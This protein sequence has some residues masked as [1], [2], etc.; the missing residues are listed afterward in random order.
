M[1]AEAD[2]Q[3]EREAQLVAGGRLA[4]REALG[5]VVKADPD[6]DV[7]RE[8]AGRGQPR[9]VVL[10]LARRRRAR[11]Q[12]ALPPEPLHPAVVPDEAQKACPEADSEQGRK[13]REPAG[14]AVVER[15]LNRI[16]RRREHVPEEEEEDAGRGRP[17]ERLRGRGD[18]AHPR[19]RQT[20]E[21]GEAGNRAEREDLGGAHVRVTLQ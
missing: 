2:D 13:P 10:V 4:D 19:E 12:E 1:E 5:E 9:E 11:A 14:V 15:G 16:D 18:V 7:D 8:P 3:D 6:G 21:D 17:E 20:E